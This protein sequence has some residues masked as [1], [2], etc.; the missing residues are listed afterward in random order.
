MNYHYIFFRLKGSYHGSVVQYDVKKDYWGKPKTVKEV[1]IDNNSNPTGFLY[2]PPGAA[3]EKLYMVLRDYRYVRANRIWLVDISS[4]KYLETNFTSEST[5]VP[6]K[7]IDQPN[8]VYFLYQNS[9]GALNVAAIRRDSDNELG[10]NFGS[11]ST[12]DTALKEYK[13]VGYPSMVS[14]DNVTDNIALTFYVNSHNKLASFHIDFNRMKVTDQRNYNGIKVIGS[15]SLIYNAQRSKYTVFYRGEYDELRYAT[16]YENGHFFTDGRLVNNRTKVLSSP[17]VI[18]DKSGA[19]VYFI[20]SGEKMWMY[21][22][23]MAGNS[24]SIMSYKDNLVSGSVSNENG[25][26]PFAIASSTHIPF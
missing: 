6:F 20:G 8:N 2:K 12:L 19:T 7:K 24:P 26:A 10:L 14:L 5:I 11:L 17:S 22:I 1:E 21:K 4:S 13:I 16:F 3:S 9:L 25:N 15:P 23:D 18:Y